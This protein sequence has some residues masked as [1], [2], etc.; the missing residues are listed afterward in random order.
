MGF[1]QTPIRKKT[2]GVTSKPLGVTSS[3]QGEN[4]KFPKIMISPCVD[5]VTLKEIKII[6]CHLAYKGG[7]SSRT[8]HFFQI[9]ISPC[10]DQVTLKETKIL[11]CRLAYKG[12]KLP[13]QTFILKSISQKKYHFDPSPQT[14][15]SINRGVATS[16]SFAA[17]RVSSSPHHEQERHL[18]N[19][20]TLHHA[21]LVD[22]SH[23]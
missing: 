5:Q 23:V 12:G 13:N 21:R 9:T 10:V 1:P 19:P 11:T 14:S 17:P 20:V 2:L 15:L 7:G 6:R 3:V 18:S 16:A 4:P 22:S 8:K